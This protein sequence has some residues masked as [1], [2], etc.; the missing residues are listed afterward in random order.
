MERAL[1][2]ASISKI[3]V[4]YDM[5]EHEPFDDKDTGQTKCAKCGRFLLLCR[6][7]NGKPILQ[8]EG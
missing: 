6:R 4:H 3:Q 2:G 1:D 8:P 7:V 5:C